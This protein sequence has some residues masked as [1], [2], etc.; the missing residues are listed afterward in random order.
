MSERLINLTSGGLGV[1]SNH[2]RAAMNITPMVLSNQ[3]SKVITQGVNTGVFI[4]ILNLLDITQAITMIIV[5]QPCMVWRA[6]FNRILANGG[7]V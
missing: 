5:L 3:Q 4:G 6:Y 2:L 7:R 1:Q